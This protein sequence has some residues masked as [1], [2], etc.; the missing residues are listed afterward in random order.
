[1]A[2]VGCVNHTTE[3]GE[4][5]QSRPNLFDIV[6]ISENS[7]LSYRNRSMLSFTSTLNNAAQ[8]DLARP[9]AIVP[10][11]PLMRTARAHLDVK[12]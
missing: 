5:T 1:M 12:M 4:L 7:R 8:G 9:C 10:P 3:A 6:Y 11:T 2:Y